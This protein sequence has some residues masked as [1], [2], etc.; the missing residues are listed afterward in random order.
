MRSANSDGNADSVASSSDW[1][2]AGPT[3][4]GSAYPITSEAIHCPAA[5]GCFFHFTERSLV[6]GGFKRGYEGHGPRLHTFGS[7]GALHL[8]KKKQLKIE[9]KLFWSQEKKETRTKVIKASQLAIRNLE[10]DTNQG[11]IVLAKDNLKNILVNKHFQTRAHWCFRSWATVFGYIKS[12]IWT[13]FQHCVTAMFIFW[14]T[15][16]TKSF[17]FIRIWALSNSLITIVNFIFIRRQIPSGLQVSL[18]SSSWSAI[19]SSA[20]SATSSV[21]CTFLKPF[22]YSFIYYCWSINGKRNTASIFKS[23]YS[24]PIHVVKV[25][26]WNRITEMCDSK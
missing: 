12:F 11:I 19:I 10:T 2:D 3:C 13:I 25:I 26:Q 20:T 15:K 1:I 14:V 9:K 18:P 8:R 16:R 7:K 23:N 4:F 22:F 5:D 21:S 6:I 17:G 24:I